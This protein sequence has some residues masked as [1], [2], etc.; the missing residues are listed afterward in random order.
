MVV[1]VARGKIVIFLFSGNLHHT[2]NL[3]YLFKSSFKPWLFII[4]AISFSY[5]FYHSILTHFAQEVERTNVSTKMYKILEL[6]NL[7]YFTHLLK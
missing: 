1:P 4:L 3:F 2:Y 6:L 5:M 7:V